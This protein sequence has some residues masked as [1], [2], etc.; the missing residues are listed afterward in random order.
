MK[1]VE[2]PRL[3]DDVA[4]FLPPGMVKEINCTITETDVI[5]SLKLSLEG[6]AVIK[7]LSG[8]R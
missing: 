8:A 7:N 3:P 6:T 2:N 4:L 1:I 5:W